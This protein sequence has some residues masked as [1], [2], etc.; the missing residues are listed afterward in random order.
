MNVEPVD[1]GDELRQGVQFCLDFAPVILCGPIARQRL[2][3]CELY[4]LGCIWNRLSLRK[5]GCVDAPAQFGQFSFRNTHLEWA[6]G[7]VIRCLLA[8]SF[9]NSGLGHR[10]LLLSVNS[11]DCMQCAIPA[12]RLMRLTRKCLRAFGV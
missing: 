11:Y 7:G 4:A 1:L 3:R 5:L 10:V 9:C 8:A 2:N 12:S 6:N